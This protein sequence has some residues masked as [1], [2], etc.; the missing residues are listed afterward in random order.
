MS[1]LGLLQP[2]GKR[3]GFFLSR[4]PK[5]SLPDEIF[6]YGL[7][8]F[9]IARPNVKSFNVETLAHEPGSPGRVFLLDEESLLERLASIEEISRGQVAWSE[10]AGLRQIFFKVD[11]TTINQ[12]KLV[13]GA[14]SYRHRAVA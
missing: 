7:L 9:A 12:L 8:R 10:T 5:P 2:I 4:G 13:A 3:D 1:E 11:P 14:Y 6:L